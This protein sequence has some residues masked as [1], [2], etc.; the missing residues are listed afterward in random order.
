[1]SSDETTVVQ[2]ILNFVL[3]CLF[4]GILVGGNQPDEPQSSEAQVNS[5]TSMAFGCTSSSSDLLGNVKSSTPYKIYKNN[6]PLS[7]SIE[8]QNA[9]RRLELLGT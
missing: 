5:M 1:V 8:K 7:E 2:Q 4:Q 3:Y 9:A 6:L